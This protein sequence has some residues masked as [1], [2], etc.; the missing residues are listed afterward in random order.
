M[1]AQVTTRQKRKALSIGALISEIDQHLD[2]NPEDSTSFF[3]NSLLSSRLTQPP[4]NP[5]PTYST[6]QDISLVAR[7]CT[8]VLSR[9]RYTEHYSEHK[10][11]I[12]TTTEFNI[13]S[14]IEECPYLEQCKRNISSKQLTH[15]LRSINLQVRA[16]TSLTFDRLVSDA[17]QRVASDV[18]LDIDSLLAKYRPLQHLQLPDENGESVDTGD[19]LQLDIATAGAADMELGYRRAYARCVKKD[20]PKGAKQLSISRSIVLNNC[21]KVSYS[22]QEAIH[23]LFGK[24]RSHLSVPKRLVD[25]PSGL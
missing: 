16:E 10:D 19:H 7:N 24:V 12:D 15:L 18:T 20:V 14:Q 17:R 25:R 22:L 2:K 4:C 9:L 13:E 6:F 21:K 23:L 11:S 5:S 3:S 8:D 1:E